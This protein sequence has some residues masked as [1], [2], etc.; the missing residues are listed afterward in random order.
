MLRLSKECEDYKHK[1]EVSDK[2]RTQMKDY[3]QKYIDK[4]IDQ[5]KKL[6][7]YEQLLMSQSYIEK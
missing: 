5:E 2:L 7:N 3:F 1:Y 4:H 6:E